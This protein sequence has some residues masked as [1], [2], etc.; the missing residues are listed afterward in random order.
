ML[1]VNI[2]ISRAYMMR[3]MN[4]ETIP[5]WAIHRR[6]YE[7]ILSFAATTIAPV[8]LFVIAVIEAFMPFVPPDVLL[9]P[10]CVEKRA[11]S[12]IFALLAISGSVLG[13]LVGYFVIASFVGSGAEWVLGADKIEMVVSEFE[14]RG[15]AYVFIAALTPV[16]F[17]ALTTA[18]GIAKLNFGVFLAACIIGRSLR[19]G[20]EALITYKFGQQAKL[21]IDKWFNTITIL[22]CV[23]GLAVWYLS[24]LL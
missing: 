11:K 16:P 5:T 3:G 20:L 2:V 7:W 17:F 8:I 10:M 4:E 13:A 6:L 18:A 23:L 21:F 22:V 19:Y 1:H 9:I 15:S 24:T 14:K 12:A